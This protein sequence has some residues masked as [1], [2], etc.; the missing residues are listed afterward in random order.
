MAFKLLFLYFFNNKEFRQDKG[1]EGNVGYILFLGVW[2][3]TNTLFF[4]WF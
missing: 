4:L 3:Q 1:N 2:G